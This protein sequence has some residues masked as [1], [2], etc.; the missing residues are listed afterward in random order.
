MK[1]VLKQTKKR[2]AWF[3][4]ARKRDDELNSRL[5]TLKYLPYEIRQQIYLENIDNYLCSSSNNSWINFR[6]RIKAFFSTPP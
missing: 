1:K 3:S 5:G 6:P 2:W 4:K